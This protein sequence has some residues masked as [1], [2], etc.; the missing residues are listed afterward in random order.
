MDK[1]LIENIL[2]DLT[3]SK[4]WLRSNGKLHLAGYHKTE[5][6]LESL[7]KEVH[8]A[9]HANKTKSKAL[10][11]EAHEAIHV[12]KTKTVANEH[13]PLIQRTTADKD[14][15]VIGQVSH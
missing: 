8:E 2:N 10:E 3:K 7:E 11:K 1:S 6:E 13:L 12:N 4:T 9:M 15:L 14:L 5:C